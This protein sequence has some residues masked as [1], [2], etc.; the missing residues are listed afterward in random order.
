MN[1]CDRLCAYSY[2]W[3]VMPPS[4]HTLERALQLIKHIKYYFYYQ[5]TKDMTIMRKHAFLG[6]MDQFSGISI[7]VNGER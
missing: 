6:R 3:I 7:H 2:A 1:N 5:R 4:G